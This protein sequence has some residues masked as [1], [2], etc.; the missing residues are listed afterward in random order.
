MRGSVGGGRTSEHA[1]PPHWAA[2]AA[3]RRTVHLVLSLG[4]HRE[5]FLRHVAHATRAALLVHDDARLLILHAPRRLEAPQS[6]DRRQP[7]HFI[8]VKYGYA[9]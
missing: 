8:G 1:P 9:M 5:A 2:P 7:W 6:R 3:H 4:L